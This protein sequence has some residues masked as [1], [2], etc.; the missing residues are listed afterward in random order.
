MFKHGRHAH[1]SEVNPAW[2]SVASQQKGL[3]ELSKKIFSLPI[4]EFR[5]LKYRPPP[6]PEDIPV[7]GRDINIAHHEIDV[8]DGTKIALRIYTPIHPPRCALLFF[9]LHGGGKLPTERCKRFSR[10]QLTKGGRLGS[11]HSGN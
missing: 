2:D 11:R 8:R 4:K 10:I 7:P 3:D 9:N 5:A 6:L 1:L